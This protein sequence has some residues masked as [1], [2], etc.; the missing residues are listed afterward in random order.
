MDKKYEML[1]LFRIA[2]GC[3]DMVGEG[4]SLK[5]Q[6]WREMILLALVIWNRFITYFKCPWNQ[7]RVSKNNGVLVR[8]FLMHLPPKNATEILWL[9]NYETTIPPYS[10]QHQWFISNILCVH[11]CI[12]FH[13]P[14]L[15]WCLIWSIGEPGM[16]KKVH[17]K[18]Q[19]PCQK[20]H[21]LCYGTWWI[22]HLFIDENQ[23]LL[24]NI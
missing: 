12:I 18:W 23:P 16:V 10:L 1:R 9:W 22:F 11:I 8:I 6:R 5:D 7:S 4:S 14:L 13:F 20:Y 2:A 21:I 19:C 24:W 15:P 17:E 3:L